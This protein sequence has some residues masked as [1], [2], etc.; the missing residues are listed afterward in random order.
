MYL[1]DM[2]YIYIYSHFRSRKTYVELSL[3][4]GLLG[5]KLSLLVHELRSAA[6]GGFESEHEVVLLL[7]ETYVLVFELLAKFGFPLEIFKSL[8]SLL[9]EG[10][11][12]ILDT[13]DVEEGLD[14]LPE[15]VPGPGTE[16]KVL[17]QVALDN[18]ESNTLFL[19]PL[20][21]LAGDVTTDPG[22][23]PGDDLSE[24][25]ITDFLKLTQDTSAEE[26][27][28]ICERRGEK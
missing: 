6:L 28:F 10:A 20:V 27:L 23:E 2:L 11:D 21:V 19:E 9:F 24:T 12:L 16:L 17:P 8:G 4:V 18:N 5:S 14:L 1:F 22:L 3:E 7:E 26:Y 13:G 25:V 15:T